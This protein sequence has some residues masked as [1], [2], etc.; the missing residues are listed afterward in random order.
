MSGQESLE[1]WFANR[2]W[3]VHPFQREA[4]AAYGK[5]EEVLI[6]APTGSGKT[7]AGLGGIIQEALKK[8]KS[9]HPDKG[10]QLIWI[11]PIRALTKEIQLS[12]QRLIDEVGLKWK[13]GTRTGD[14]AGK[15]RAAQ[16][17][18]LPEML[19]TTPESLHVL[20]AMR[21]GNRRFGQLKLMV[22][23]EWHELIGSKRGVQVELASSWLRLQSDSY[24]I[25][26]I[27]ATIGNMNQALNVL[28]GQGAQGRII[29]SR[30]SKRIEVHS[31]MP[32]RF[33][34]LP[35]A[36]HI[37]VKLATEVSEII[38]AHRST[39]I[40]TNTRAQSEIWYHKLL[41]VAPELSGVLA[42]HHSSIAKDLRDWVENALHQ[43]S[44]KAV[45]CTSSL[46][47]GVDFRP[48]EA[49]VQIGGPKGIA[50]F[51]QRAG[52]SGHQ[53]GAIS[54]IYFLP[55]HGLELI[56]AAALRDATR[57]GVIES[58]E[59]L[60][61]TFDVLIQFLCTVAVGDG[62]I[63]EEMANC[64][65]STHAFSEMSI[66][67]WRWCLSFVLDGGPALSAYGDYHRVF[68][69]PETGKWVM[70]DR[71]LTRRH[72]MSIGTIVSDQMIQVK[73]S[74]GGFIGHV[75]EYFVA[76]MEPGDAF[77]FAGLSLEFVRL[78]EGVVL[79][80]KSNKLKGR[81]P[82]Y[83]GGRLSLSSE[84]G[85]AIR[86][87]LDAYAQGLVRSP[88]MSRVAPLLE[89]Q[90]EMSLLPRKDEILVE[91][92]ES[93]DGF[94]I[95]V[96]P[97]EGRAVHEAIGM[98]LAHRWCSY[99]PLSMSIAC[100]DYGFEL[101]SDTPIDAES[102]ESLD[103]LSLEGLMDDLQSG[104]NATEM[105]KRRFRDIAV[106]AGLTFQGFPG[107]HQGVRHLQSHAGLLFEVFQDFDA[108]NLL[109]R[110]AYEELLNQ[111]ME[112]S[113]LRQVLNR[114]RSKKVQIMTT[115]HPTPFSFPLVVDR[116][117]DRM[118]SEQLE[119]RI[120]KMVIQ[121]AS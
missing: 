119:T 59:P 117:R 90:Q 94:H 49:I 68:E 6:Q 32:D 86:D 107:K 24:R 95:C 29:T 45:V 35:W 7:Y 80:K 17:R 114:I 60:M 50:R 99:R 43:G 14:T 37:G 22:V 15:E 55:T 48:V 65:A 104:I 116:L 5:G 46:D 113:R 61:Q 2:G 93:D 41:E 23:D 76:S 118:S 77:W 12:A 85:H 13:V 66:E 75:E 36:G 79:V 71:K 38:Q 42:L 34:R 78:K 98:L 81:I 102:I 54:S 27:S 88:E 10:L 25:W 96:F 53:P 31:I 58:R 11:A 110:Q 3:E 9:G 16:R 44:L 62:F 87:E 56:E 52:R 82:V 21:D 33:E 73:W 57:L 84:L 30:L 109:Y 69:D 20:I 120:Q 108:E 103:L 28:K 92:F 19:I 111:Q 115:E 101:L 39:L 64:V 47:L 8:Q 40:F 74:K 97:F 67:E 121:S 83:L 100:N 63:P 26:G 51:I 106:I 105:A 18:E 112:W 91:Q 70:R 89:L 1:L 4:W 72:R